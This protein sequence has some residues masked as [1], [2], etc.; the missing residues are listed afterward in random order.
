MKACKYCGVAQPDENFEVCRVLGAKVYRRL[1]CKRCKQEAATHRRRG[2]RAWLDAYKRGLRC[3]RCGFTDFRALQFHHR[4]EEKE[5]NVADMVRH[6]LSREAIEREI[7]KCRTLCANCH[8]I[9]HY[10]RRWA[11]GAAPA[12]AFSP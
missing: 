11:R 1:K 9:E 12:A 3:E 2:L 7:G 8:L 6:G 10:E 4:T 5:F